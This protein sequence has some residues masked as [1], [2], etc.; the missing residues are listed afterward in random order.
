MVVGFIQWRIYAVRLLWEV[1]KVYVQDIS[2]FNTPSRFVR[3][4]I[5]EKKKN[6][7]LVS[8]LPTEDLFT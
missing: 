6:V 4:F 3:R 7:S 1:Y 8:F 2:L 5:A